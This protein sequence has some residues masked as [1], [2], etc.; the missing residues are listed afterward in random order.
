MF[1]YSSINCMMAHTG[2]AGVGAGS[3]FKLTIQVPFGVVVGSRPCRGVT[4]IVS[5]MARLPLSVLPFLKL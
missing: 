3:I 5:Y 1:I 2:V 4:S